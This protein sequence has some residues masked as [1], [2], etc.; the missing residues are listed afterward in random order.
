MSDE[1]LR[2]S[3]DVLA[4]E[5]TLDC[6]SCD[7]TDAVF[8]DGDFGFA[9][10]VPPA[11]F[12]SCSAAGS[13]LT[14]TFAGVDGLEGG[15]PEGVRTTD[16]LVAVDFVEMVER[17][18]VVDTVRFAMGVGFAVSAGEG[19][20]LR[21]T[22]DV[23]LDATDG[24]L[25]G[26]RG[27]DVPVVR[28]LTVDT[29]DAADPRRVRPT[30]LGVS[31][32][33]AVSNAV[34][35]SLVDEVESVDAGREGDGGGRSVEGPAAV[36]R[37]VEVV[38]R[39]DLTEAATDFGLGNLSAFECSDGVV[40]LRTLAVDI[41]LLGTELAFGDRG[42][43]A[44]SPSAIDPRIEGE[45]V[46]WA[47]V[48]LES[49]RRLPGDK[50]TRREI[51][52]VVTRVAVEWVLRA[53]ERTDAAEDLGLSSGRRLGAALSVECTLTVSDSSAFDTGPFRTVR[54]PPR[55]VDVGVA[56]M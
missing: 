2:L 29:D 41:L 24:G 8:D 17:T 4:E 40:D 37:I 3:V 26:V 30:L 16:F 6:F 36:L 54:R 9:L 55:D 31:S 42:D 53:T 39:V 1:L 25:L 51:V 18:E 44:R 48:S 38:E 46:E 28:T 21:L 19:G 14:P 12:S 45:G 20:G 13:G 27:V 47:G 11:P 52:V 34:E 56:G 33:R 35:F 10:I 7:T 43:F 22:D 15:V 50:G 32:E 23:V 49:G 5:T